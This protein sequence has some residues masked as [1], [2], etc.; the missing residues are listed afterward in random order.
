MDLMHTPEPA[1]VTP[2]STAIVPTT[3]LGSIDAYRGFVMFLMMAEVLHLAAIAA[4]K[5][6]NK[7]WAFLAHHQEHVP[8]V[9]CTL[10]DLIQPS[11]S[12]LVGVALP[13]SLAARRAKGQS[14]GGMA[15]H[16]F[17]RAFV[18]IAL[19]IFLRSMGEKVTQT[20]FT[21]EDTLTQIGLGYGFLFLIGQRS[22]RVAW[23]ALVV[24]LV[25]YFAAFALY[26]L[27]GAEFDWAAAGASPDWPHNLNGFAAHWNKNTNL[28]WRFDVWFMNLFP[29]KEPFL[30]N[31]GGYS[32]LSF[33]PTLATMILGLIAGRWIAN[34]DLTPWRRV[35]WLVVAGVVTL[36]AGYALGEFGLC[37]I[38]KRI[39]TPS[40]TLY[41][42]GWCF[43]L[44]ASFY[45][46]IDVIGLRF[47][48]RPL[49]VIGANS[50]AAY[51]MAHTIDG[52]LER[53]YRIHLGPNIFKTFG[54][55]YEPLT[56]GAFVLGTMW[57]ILWWMYRKRIFVR[58]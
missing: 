58:I 21:F 32:T 45:A 22:A 55:A 8:W 11:F 7:V 49:E 14:P 2:P 17:W 43:L 35:G 54:E 4:S 39:W 10:H 19:G 41:S 20:N 51:V 29:R 46:T 53:S 28:A 42:G 52:F 40:W 24:I 15:L 33:L 3:R 27:P 13:F 12:F 25:G 31:G 16:A 38:V 37:P 5:P 56:Q 6:G 48:A 44:L 34:T 23:I 36:G 1:A 47:W 30:F 18:L 26:P 57:L 9:G 50:I